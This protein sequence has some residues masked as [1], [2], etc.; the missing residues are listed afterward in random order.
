MKRKEASADY[1]AALKNCFDRWEHLRVYGGSDP[2]F[3]DGVNMNLVRNHIMYYKEKIEETLPPYPEIYHRETPPKVDMDYMA[4][5]DE[6]REN[7]K[8]SLAQFEGN[9]SLRY[10]R[11]AVRELID[12]Q[13]DRLHIPNILGYETAL[14]MAIAEDDLITMRRYE[15]P[16]RYLQSF[17]QAANAV[18][19]LEPEEDFQMR[20]F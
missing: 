14:R 12:T 3:A 15:N 5:P 11:E 18:R 20:F 16:E 9:D 17:E 13:A 1:E 2:S 4:R 19:Q 8:I 7:A 10:L 6:I